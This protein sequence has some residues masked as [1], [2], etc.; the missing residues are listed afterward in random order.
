MCVQCER[1]LIFIAVTIVKN[2]TFS[3]GNSAQEK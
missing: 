3:K 1:V 2:L